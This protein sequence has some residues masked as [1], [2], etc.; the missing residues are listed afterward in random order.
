MKKVA[1]MLHN[2]NRPHYLKKVLKSYK[3]IYNFKKYDLYFFQDGAI[4]ESGKRRSGNNGIKKCT[5]LLKNFDDYEELFINK[6]NRGVPYQFV[7]G[8]DKLLNEYNYD[9][10]FGMEN[11][12]VVGKYYF[13][14]AL[15]LYNQFGK[16]ALYTSGPGGLSLDNSNSNPEDVAI[17]S[18]KRGKGLLHN[19]YTFNKV[20]DYMY[21]YINFIGD[22]YKGRPHHKIRKKYNVNI[23]SYDNIQMWALQ[24]HNIPIIHTILPRGL[25]IGEY[26]IHSNGWTKNHRWP[27]LELYENDNDK[28]LTNFNI[29][30]NQ[31][32]ENYGNIYYY[33]IKYKQS[34]ENDIVAFSSYH[35][36]ND[37]ICGSGCIPILHAKEVFYDKNNIARDGN[38]FKYRNDDEHE[39]ILYTKNKTN[40]LNQLKE[41]K[42]E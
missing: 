6:Y 38:L 4:T 17:L 3:N 14:V 42:D 21:E 29:K 23:T 8:Y 16:E 25:Y 37:T 31:Y 40:F 7:H 12:I 39:L 18:G 15:N 1:I 11:D 35:S 41:I 19:S 30:I 28:N 5:M 26:G 36:K 2:F 27:D 13:H 10:V 22:D 32:S 9:L 34:P 33:I 20:K 24:K